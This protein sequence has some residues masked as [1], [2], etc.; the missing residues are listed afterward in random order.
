MG[1]LLAVVFVT[2]IV[3]R[4]A[5][6]GGLPAEGDV[7]LA[8]L[9]SIVHW[10]LYLLVPIA[11]VLGLA[12]VWA[13]GDVIYNLFAI[14]ALDPRNRALRHLIGDWHL[15]AANAIMIVTALHAV[16]AL[17]HHYVLRDGVLRRMLPVA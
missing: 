5:H 6:R 17:F 13:G 9:A 8:R 1:A 11:L 4:T 16:P 3:W 2:R 14:P 10:V 15:L 7:W 12:N